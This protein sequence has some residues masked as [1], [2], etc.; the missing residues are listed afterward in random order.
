M[1]SFAYT[2]PIIAAVMNDEGSA[3]S[4]PCALYLAPTKALAN[5]QARAW[6]DLA[7]PGSVKLLSMEI[8]TPM[9]ERGPAGTQTSF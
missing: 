4:D 6:R 7:L 9:T 5:D 3:L 8:A 2:M 1:V